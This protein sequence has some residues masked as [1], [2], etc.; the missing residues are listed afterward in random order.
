[1]REEALESVSDKELT[2]TCSEMQSNELKTDIH[3][4]RRRF[5]FLRRRE[6]KEG[7]DKEKE[8]A[9]FSIEGSYHLARPVRTQVAVSLPILMEDEGSVPVMH[10]ATTSSTTSKEK[11]FPGRQFHQSLPDTPLSNRVINDHSPDSQFV[12]GDEDYDKDSLSVVV[13]EPELVLINEPK[14]WESFVDKKMVKKLSKNERIRQ[15]IIYGMQHQTNIWCSVPIVK[16]DR[17]MLQTVKVLTCYR[18]DS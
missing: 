5:T 10:V 4:P 2:D 7:K 14:S 15:E 12:Y 11:E 13:N 1:M 17:L 16:S 3:G 6:N 18:I 8:R 9:K